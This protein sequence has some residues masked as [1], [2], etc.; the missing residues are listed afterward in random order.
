[1]RSEARRT[2]EAMTSVE[3]PRDPDM[4]FASGPAERPGV[5]RHCAAAAAGVDFEIDTV[6]TV[7]NAEQQMVARARYVEDLRVSDIAQDLSVSLPA[8]SQRLKTIHKVL[9]PIVA[10]AVA[11]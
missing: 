1:M 11:A 5:R 9:R 10:E 2:V 7:L 3:I 6:L 4:L 8:I